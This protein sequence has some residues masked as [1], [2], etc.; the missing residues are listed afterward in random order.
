VVEQQFFL[1]DRT[2]LHVSGVA[3]RT[4]VVET[5]EHREFRVGQIIGLRIEPGA[6]LRLRD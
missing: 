2:R 6:L 4:V 1:G 3:D 5:S